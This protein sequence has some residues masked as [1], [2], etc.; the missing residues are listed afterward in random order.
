MSHDRGD[1]IPPKA[2]YFYWALCEVDEA[3]AIMFA[4]V[5]RD[6]Q[7]KYMYC[8]EQLAKDGEDH[9]GKIIAA[10]IKYRLTETL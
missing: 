9:A 4:N 1:A 2:Q 5:N 3:S 8:V 7:D 6:V 10:F